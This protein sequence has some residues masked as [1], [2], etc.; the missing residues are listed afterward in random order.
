MIRLT[1]ALALALTVP[2]VAQAED[3][4]FSAGLGPHFCLRSIACRARCPM[5][6]EVRCSSACTA[7]LALCK[8]HRAKDELLFRAALVGWASA[9]FLGSPDNQRRLREARPMNTAG[10]LLE[11]CESPQLLDREECVNV[12]GAWGSI[13]IRNG[14]ERLTEIKPHRPGSA[15]CAT[16]PISDADFA[17]AFI[18]W[19]RRHPSERDLDLPAALD[20][21]IAA[22][23]PCSTA[24]L[25]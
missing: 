10:A 17:R 6:H 8:A 22:A 13:M 23:W 12:A 21:A 3:R 20:V 14:R 5:E 25:E 2:S 16:S 1:I 18:A 7:S 15:A 11:R 9:R 24:P 19:S 4:G